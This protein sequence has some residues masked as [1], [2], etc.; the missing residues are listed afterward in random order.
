[1]GHPLVSSTVAC[2]FLRKNP[3]SYNA[4]LLV[5]PAIAY[6]SATPY[7]SAPSCV[8]PP[9]VPSLF[10]MFI[11]SK[12]QRRPFSLN[13]PKPSDSS[14]YCFQGDPSLSSSAMG[15]TACFKTLPRGKCYLYEVHQEVACKSRGVFNINQTSAYP[16]INYSA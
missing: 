10:L 4:S 3:I 7:A 8:F 1:M 15:N 6:A 16:S 11:V 13:Q 9:Q 14:L 2:T 5:V 12:T